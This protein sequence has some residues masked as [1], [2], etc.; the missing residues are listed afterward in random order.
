MKA[1]EFMQSSQ[2][3]GR[4]CTESFLDVFKKETNR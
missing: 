4:S 2:L 1:L 3:R